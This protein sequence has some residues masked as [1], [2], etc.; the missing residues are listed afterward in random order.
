[1]AECEPNVH[2][3]DCDLRVWCFGLPVKCK[4]LVPTLLVFN[5]IRVCLGCYFVSRV[6]PRHTKVLGEIE[7]EAGILKPNGVVD[8][9]EFL[10]GKAVSILAL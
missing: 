5:F 4:E 9:K 8:K 2:M 6:V 1:M 3:R 7:R 10:E